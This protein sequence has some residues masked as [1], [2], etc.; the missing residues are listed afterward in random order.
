MFFKISHRSQCASIALVLAA[1]LSACGGGSS[2]PAVN[3]GNA[4]IPPLT[5]EKSSGGSTSP[6][7]LAAVWLQTT[8]I[9]DN[10]ASRFLTQATFGPKTTD[11]AR[12]KSLGYEAWLNEQLSKP[13]Q[14]K[15]HLAYYDERQIAWRAFDPGSNAAYGDVLNSFWTQALVGDDQLRQRVAFALSEI[16]VVS[17]AD[18]CGDANSRGMADYMDMLTRQAFGNYRQLLEKVAMHPVMGCYLSHMHNQK[19]DATTGR[20]PDE[21]FAREIMQL[22]SIGLYELN[23]DGTKVMT[24]DKANETYGPAD[25]AGLA[26]VFTGFSLD[27]PMPNDDGCFDRGSSYNGMKS[28]SDRWIKPMLAYPR[29]HSTAEKR[30]LGKVLA[31]QDQP[32]PAASVKFALDTI[33]QH[34]NV[35]PFIGKQLIQRL[36]TSN[37]SPAYVARVANAF[38]LSNGSLRAMVYATLMDPEARD[39]QAALT[40]DSFGKVR[41]PILRLS[42]LLRAFNVASDSGDYLISLT[43]DPTFGLNQAPLFSPSVFNFFRPGYAPPGSQ[44]ADQN[45]VAPEL[46]LANETS[47]A[48]YMR[49]VSALITAG[50]GGV[51]N[52][53]RGI[54]GVK[55]GDIR[56][57]FLDNP[58]SE[59]RRLAEKPDDL[60]QAI[61]QRLFYGA[62]SPELKADMTR[63]IADITDPTPSVRQYQRICLALILAMSTPEFIVQR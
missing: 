15:S 2:A 35:G 50:G 41:E 47:V 18:K 39:M 8:P 25:I 58:N 29:F 46:Q 57:E 26:K 36:V 19:E 54:N 51:P 10:E 55:R 38:K 53:G 7:S 5:L 11:I 31:V 4:S 52:F 6:E 30:L 23:A 16:F 21:N 60:T 48:G 1:V 33:A 43:S 3:N 9:T 34:P 62:M 49:Y 28:D 42:A 37:P 59:L 20:V 27:C 14:A 61:N 44:T 24:G 56:L 12:V 13:L 45:L 63:V 17:F 22:F 40:S 32:A